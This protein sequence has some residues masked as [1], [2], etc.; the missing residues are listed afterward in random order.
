MAK[1][2]KHLATA[3]Q[4]ETALDLGDKN[5]AKIKKLQTFDFSSFV[6]KR[7]FDDDGILHYLIF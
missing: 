6:G 3:N 1:A 4:V 7:Y 5:R 2:S